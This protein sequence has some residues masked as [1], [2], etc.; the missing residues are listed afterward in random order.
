VQMLAMFCV[1]MKESHLSRLT[2]GRAIRGRMF[3]DDD[4]CR[5]IRAW[6]TPVCA[7]FIHPSWQWRRFASRR[8]RV[9]GSITKTRKVRG[10]LAGCLAQA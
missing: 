8:G 4:Y 1:A 7:P 3:E 9:F 5:R 6:V 10:W 2:A